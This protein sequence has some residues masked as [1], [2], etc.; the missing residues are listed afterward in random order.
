P[1]PWSRQPDDVRPTET[2]GTELAFGTPQE[3]ALGLLMPVQWYPM[4]E[5]ALHAKHATGRDDHLRQASEMWARFSRVAVDNPYA[6]VRR[7]SSAEAIRTPRADNRMIGWPYPK[8]MNSNNHVDQG[9]ALILCSAAAARRFGVPTDRWVYLHG[10]AEATDVAE[11]P[12]RWDLAGSPA[13]RA[14]GAEALRAAA[15]GIDDLA[16]VDLYSCFPS[17]VQVAA[18]ELGLGLERELTVTGGLTF[19][20]GPWNNYVTHAIATMMGRLRVDPGAYGLCTANGGHLSKHA[21]GVY[22]CRPPAAA[23]QVAHPQD[24]VETAPAR[25]VLDD[26]S[27]DARIETFT[28]MHD[29]EGQAERGFVACLDTEGRRALV[30]TDDADDLSRLV[31][32]DLIGTRVKLSGQTLRLA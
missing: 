18:D 32:E 3:V 31:A 4:F 1:S 5:N 17:A 2:I 8:L 28:V 20:G 25:Q 23:L 22:S 7:P 30:A 6:A 14:A 29:R 19:A 11:V 16:Y 15:I 27:G 9:A 12:R 10:A 26:P 13:I 24:V 21:V